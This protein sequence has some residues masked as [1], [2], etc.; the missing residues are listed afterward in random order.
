MLGPCSLDD[1]DV[2]QAPSAS[3][4][5]V[6][7]RG[8]VTGVVVLIILALLVIGFLVVACRRFLSPG[9]SAV[10][11][12]ISAATT[13]VVGPLDADGYP[14]YIA[15]FN[16]RYSCGVT[17]ENNVEV[18][19]RGVFFNGD[20]T[21]DRMR[22]HGRALG[23]TPLPT[24]PGSR[25]VSFYTFVENEPPA[26]AEHYRQEDELEG[27][28]VAR[29]H[30]KHVEWL[31]QHAAVL[32]DFALALERP[33]WFVPMLDSRPNSG[34]STGSPAPQVGSRI[35]TWV[36]GSQNL[37][38]IREVARLL[39]CRIRLRIGEGDA[40]GAVR[41]MSRLIDFQGR[42]LQGPHGWDRILGVAVGAMMFGVLDELL[43]MPSLTPEQADRL[44]RDWDRWKPVGVWDDVA[45]VSERYHVLA[46][47]VHLARHGVAGVNAAGVVHGAGE[48]SEKRLLRL[49][50]F[51]SWNRVD[52]DAA[53]IETN[54][55][56]DEMLRI[57][58]MSSSRIRTE[59]LKLFRNAL[60]DQAAETGSVWSRVTGSSLS[61]REHQA[62]KLAAFLLLEQPKYLESRVDCRV[63][64]VA[65]WRVGRLGI[66]V[67][68]F[69]HRHQRWPADFAEIAGEFGPRDTLDSHLESREIVYR[70]NPCGF[71]VHGVGP[72]GIDN[73]GWTYGEI[74][75]H[76]NNSY[77]DD[78]RVRVGYP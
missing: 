63:R 21:P 7:D 71:L 8:R 50:W 19:L 75:P 36:G 42:L 13:R 4:M 48:K 51:T 47:V 27:P 17:P 26:L 39:C 62:R 11:V 73:H 74:D 78:T 57:E 59:E 14:D 38:D 40:S 20:A 54:R 53:L 18:A 76:S 49:S 45:D 32:D 10:R 77:C 1:F 66:D 12:T 41:D 65:R 33:R 15:A 58:R 46:L 16:A 30:P 6:P 24:L 61:S 55:L 2:L 29:D 56:F 31:D 69:R 9:P 28:W 44:S 64:L 5:T 34:S 67:V 52:W 72:N 60:E 37:F 22:E 3:P 68:R 23:V 70:A 25:F 35:Q 43:A